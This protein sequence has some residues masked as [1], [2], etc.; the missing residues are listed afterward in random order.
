MKNIFK[1]DLQCR[2][3]EE[4]GPDVRG[5]EGEVEWE[6]G[7]VGVGERGGRGRNEE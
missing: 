7:G 1:F 4:E 5:E 3:S 6:A 2:R